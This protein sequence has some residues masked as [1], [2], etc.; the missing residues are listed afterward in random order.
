[1]AEPRA[2]ASS[3]VDNMAAL[4]D[5]LLDPPAPPAPRPPRL[6]G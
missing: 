1:L 3:I 5:E 6:T 2:R 4:L